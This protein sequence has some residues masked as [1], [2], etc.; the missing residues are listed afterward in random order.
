[1]FIYLSDT[2]LQ[3]NISY[4]AQI[5]INEQINNYSI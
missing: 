1:M 4:Q 2:P 5:R 3:N